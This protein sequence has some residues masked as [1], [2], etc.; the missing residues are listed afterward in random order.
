MY[1]LHTT[2]QTSFGNREMGTHSSEETSVAQHSVAHKHAPDHQTPQ[3]RHSWR[4]LVSTKFS[5]PPFRDARWR[6]ASGRKWTAREAAGRSFGPRGHSATGTCQSPTTQLRRM[7]NQSPGRPFAKQLG[8]PAV[9]A[10]KV[11]TISTP[12]HS[13]SPSQSHCSETR[14]HKGRRTAAAG[15]RGNQPAVPGVALPKQPNQTSVPGAL[16]VAAL[17]ST[18]NGIQLGMAACGV[19]SRRAHASPSVMGHPPV[20]QNRVTVVLLDWQ[21]PPSSP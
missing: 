18:G 11:R 3:T 16:G 4:V 19:G 6:R 2:R 9:Q 14:S 5:I 17:S 8:A 21:G 10:A 12:C 15:P 7:R 20:T 13:R 1:N